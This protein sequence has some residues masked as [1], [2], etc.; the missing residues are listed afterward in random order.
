[1]IFLKNS[2]SKTR[3]F[4]GIIE[5]KWLIGIGG[6]AIAALVFFIILHGK[7]QGN[8]TFR[9]NHFQLNFDPSTLS[10][11]ESRKV[12]TMLHAGLIAVDIDGNIYPRLAE[13]WTKTDDC[14]W[15]FK[16]RKNVRF[17]NGE[18]VDAHSVVRSLSWA[19]QNT[20]LYSWCLSSIDHI[21]HE[22]GTIECTGLSVLDDFT[23]EIREALP[24]P[25]FLESLDSP[26]GWIIG[27][28]DKEPG[29]W[30]MRPG[31]GPFKIDDMKTDS[32]IT[33]IARNDGAF[34]PL[35]DRVTFRAIADSTVAAQML[36]QGNL[37]LLHVESPDTLTFFNK[38]NIKLMYHD[39]QRYRV[40]IISRHALQNKGFTAK[41]IQ[42][43]IGMY[44]E[45]INR[46][47]ISVLSNGI[48]LPMRTAFPPAAK[49]KEY[50]P[51]SE[52]IIEDF[53]NAQLTLLTTNDAYADLIAS[54]LPQKVKGVEIHYRAIE[55]SLLMNALFSGEAD[56]ISMLIDA[57]SSAPIF[58]ASF[59]TP[60]SSFVTFGTPLS[61]LEGLNFTTEQDITTAAEAVDQFGNW[62]G[63][64][65]EKGILA[66]SQRLDGWRLTPSGQIC[67]EGVFIATQD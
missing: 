35:T 36:R 11:I 6:L 19:M 2:S 7:A 32:E 44:S 65:Q 62:A 54:A 12:A 26:A 48:G 13:S 18:P 38:E 52:H 66:V 37:D 9:I 25:W 22:N 39:F 17:S 64:L 10:D 67:Y 3:K 29:A 55:S 28:T 24:V 63:V 14:T 59:W 43:F 30:G 61:V 53:P 23:V 34:T 5:K 33:L 31:I 40:V 58:W 46:E 16:L 15:V 27:E 1:M 60:N 49:L 47:R 45:N 50:V 42:A 21:V 51:F 20:H 57:T 56:L 41:Q 4:L 8:L